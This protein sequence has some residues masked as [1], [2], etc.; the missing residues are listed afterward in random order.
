MS[1]SSSS[2]LLVCWCR[3]RCCG[4]AVALRWLHR[5]CRRAR[6]PISPSPSPSSTSHRRPIARRFLGEIGSRL[7]STASAVKLPTVSRG[8]R[9]RGPRTARPAPTALGAPRPPPTTHSPPHANPPRRRLS[10]LPMTA[11]L[12]RRLPPVWRWTRLHVSRSCSRWDSRGRRWRR[13]LSSPTA[14]CDARTRAS[15]S[16]AARACDIIRT[17]TLLMHVSILSRVSVCVNA[18]LTVLVSLSRHS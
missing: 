9:G 12:R 1:S 15:S 18:R 7:G 2:L 3:R 16:R 11:A 14:T 6:R 4:A 5:L 17:D 8:S 13:R 10:R